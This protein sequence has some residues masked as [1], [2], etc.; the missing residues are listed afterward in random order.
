MEEEA[1]GTSEMLLKQIADNVAN[2]ML[3]LLS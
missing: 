1:N 2:G 3:G